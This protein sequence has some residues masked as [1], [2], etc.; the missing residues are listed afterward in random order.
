M[1]EFFSPL[2]LVA[3]P[4]LGALVIAALSRRDPGAACAFR[5]WP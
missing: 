1:L 2:V 5:R 3:F 4:A